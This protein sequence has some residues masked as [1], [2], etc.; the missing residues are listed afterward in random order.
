MELNLINDLM[1]N[2]FCKF[3]QITKV[4][5]IWDINEVKYVEALKDKKSILI[6]QTNNEGRYVD[7]AILNNQE[8]LLLYQC[9]KAFFLKRIIN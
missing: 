6:L 5:S 2:N 8:N 3:D 4:D 9:K 1:N 7:F